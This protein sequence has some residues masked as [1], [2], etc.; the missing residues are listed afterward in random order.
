[1]HCRYCDK[2]LTDEEAC[3]KDADGHFPDV[4]DQCL[5]D[6][7]QDLSDFNPDDTISILDDLDIFPSI[8]DEY[9]G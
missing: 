7:Y 6:T 5:S 4:C 3:I 8:E 9:G 1:M 2:V